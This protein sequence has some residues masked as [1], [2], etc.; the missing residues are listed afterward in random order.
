MTEFSTQKETISPRLAMVLPVVGKNAN[1]PITTHILVRAN[2]TVCELLATDKKLATL[3]G[4]KLQNAVNEDVKFTV[5]GKKVSDFLKECENG[6]VTFTYDG[7]EKSLLVLSEP[8]QT[9]LPLSCLDPKDFPD[10]ETEFKKTKPLTEFKKEALLAGLAFAE[11]FVA[12]SNANDPTYTVAQFKDGAFSAGTGRS[13]GQYGDK[14]YKTDAEFKLRGTDIS[15][16]RS[17][18]KQCTSDDI[19]VVESD[20]YNFF[21]SGTNYIGCVKTDIKPPKINIPKTDDEPHGMN[22]AKMD[23]LKMIARLR[24]AAAKDNQRID[25]SIAKG[26][27]EIKGV[28]KNE[29][30]A[31]ASELMEITTTTGDGDVSFALDY[32][33]LGK[34]L[35]VMEN[36]VIAFHYEPKKKYVKLVDATDNARAVSFLAVLR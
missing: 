34:C 35:E 11:K 4:F 3:V 29:Q 32:T 20:N 31:E 17:F 1:E 15:A 16:L 36:P 6:E 10:F 26:A 18:V 30:G 19:E 33:Y 23:L 13:I 22:I 25:L 21:K 27:K 28:I 14:T 9:K 12:S 24:I 5:D 2:D 7:K 8:R